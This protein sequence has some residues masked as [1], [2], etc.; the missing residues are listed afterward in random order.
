MLSLAKI[1]TDGIILQRGTPFRVWGW[2]DGDVRLS[3]FSEKGGEPVFRTVCKTASENKEFN[4]EFPAVTDTNSFYYIE[5]ECDKEKIRFKARFGNVYLA[6]GQSNMSYSLGSVEKC[7]EIA[8]RA[9]KAEVAFLALSEKPFTDV[10]EVT[11]PVFPLRDLADDYR[12]LSGSSKEIYGVSA[13]AVATATVLYEK[14]GVPTAFIVASMGGLCIESFLPREVAEADCEVLEFTREVG[15]YQPIESYNTA[16]VR[17][18][19]QLSGVFN[20]KIAPLS[21]LSFEGIVWYLGESSA[22]D[23]RFARMF[24]KELSLLVK[25][26]R[27]M[28]GGTFAAVGIACEYYPYGDAHGYEYINEALA[29]LEEEFAH[30]RF[31]PIHDIE[32]RWLKEDGDLY[33]HPIH[34]VNKL[35]LAERVAD[36]FVSG[37]KYPRITKVFYE[38]GQAVC[39]A[40]NVCGGF[41]KESVYGFTLAGADGKYYPAT[42]EADGSRIVVSCADVS[43]PCSLTYAFKLYQNGCVLHDASGAPLLPYRTKSEAVRDGYCFTPAYLELNG[44][45]TYENCFGSDVGTCR[46]VAVWQSGEIYRSADVKIEVANGTLCAEAQPDNA[47]YFMFGISPAVCLSGHKSHLADYRYLNFELCA[48]KG[49][50]TFL[51]AV[52]RSSSGDV[53]RFELCNGAN[54]AQSLPVGK[55]FN[56]FAVNLSKGLRCDGAPLEFAKELRKNFVQVEFLFRSKVRAII[57]LRKISLSDTNDSRK[58]A[59]T[60]AQ[61][62]SRADTKL[63]D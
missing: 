20:E 15:R 52:A 13:I 32:P 26:Y 25:T 11:R 60:A 30:Y 63:P 6:T 33:Y 39:S 18:Y 53:Y 16:G 3:L 8:A 54:S 56:R 21:G 14:T 50:V 57:K 9:A 55:K 28:F 1:F 47:G 5:A 61:I 29:S 2:A 43:E 27:A 31:V 38:K 44:N 35:P 59:E 49:E 19:T 12:W 7:D 22:W 62:P 48:E 40:E 10:S 24:K 46:K 41:K 58:L 36:T 23:Y 4:G 42:A 45:Q 37:R 51:G 34:P 17:N